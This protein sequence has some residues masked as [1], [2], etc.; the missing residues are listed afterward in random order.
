MILCDLSTTE[1]R[2]LL[3][4]DDDNDDKNDNHNKD[5]NN[6]YANDSAIHSPSCK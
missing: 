2:D 5:A 1:L 6:D 3:F 4:R